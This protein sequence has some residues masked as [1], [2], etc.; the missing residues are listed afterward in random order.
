VVVA[1]GGQHGGWSLYV[2]GGRP[3]FAV[4]RGGKDIFVLDS[5]ISL[6][7]EAQKVSGGEVGERRK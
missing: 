4:K 6:T 5:E 3:R 1:S 2:E 7:G